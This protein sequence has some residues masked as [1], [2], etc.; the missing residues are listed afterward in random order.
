ML[1]LNVNHEEDFL[2]ALADTGA[3]ISSILK[4]HSSKLMTAI[5]PPGEQVEL[6]FLK[7]KLGYSCDI[8][9]PRVQSQETN[10]LF[11]RI[12]CE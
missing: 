11:L 5:Q 8:F 1:I 12:S 6:N 7:I 2:R 3:I 9:I 10:V 4:P